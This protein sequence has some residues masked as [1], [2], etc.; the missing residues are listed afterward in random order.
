MSMFNK[1]GLIKFSA[2]LM[3]ALVILA[4]TVVVFQYK[5]VDYIFNGKMV[6]ATVVED[7]GGDKVKVVYASDGGEEVFAK[8][9]V[10]QNIAKGDKLNLY[11]S[12]K[13]TDVLYQIPSRSM[14]IM[15]DV[16]LLF[17][18]FLG[19]SLV[20]RMLKKLRKYKKLEKKGVKTQATITSV[21]NTSGVLG[22]DIE[23][24]D[25]AGN[26]RSTVYYPT[27]DIPNVGE[28]L[29]IIYYIKRTGKIVFIVPKDE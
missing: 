16:V 3:A 7:L 25:A 23:F 12:K 4:V 21:K 6:A 17:V 19:W 11:Y 10:K 9:V 8:A 29:D 15:F 14:I 27:S 20:M 22:A 28:N 24:T 18:E 13:H 26:K 1:K 5:Q 2:L